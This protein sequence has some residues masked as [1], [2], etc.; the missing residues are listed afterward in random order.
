MLSNAITQ[1]L[2]HEG[3][4]I[5]L[6]PDNNSETKRHREYSSTTSHGRPKAKSAEAIKSLNDIR[7]IQNYFLNAGRIRDYMMF[8]V[9][10]CSGLRVSDLTALKIRDIFNED[11]SFKECISIYEQKTGKLSS[12]IDGRCLITEAMRSAIKMYIDSVNRTIDMDEYLLWSRK[13][14]KDTGEHVITEEY[15]WAIMKDAQR[16]LGLHYNIG[17]HTMRKSAANIALCV[18][19]G[20]DVD[21]SKLTAIQLILHHSDV[22][23]TMRYLN[24]NSI[25]TEKVRNDIS[26]FVLGKTEY[27][28]LTEAFAKRKN[29]SEV[30]TTQIMEFIQGLIASTE[31]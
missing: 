19:D 6:F 5:N 22:R 29:S 10:I 27:N 18:S 4:I 30:D 21:M 9:G 1:G 24:I 11:M 8:T 20:L 26:D 12:G 14:R 31:G 15:G 17:S 16:A 3:K 28:D 23:T 2:T 7:A 25:L 13:S